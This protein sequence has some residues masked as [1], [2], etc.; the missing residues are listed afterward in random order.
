[1]VTGA[2]CIGVVTLIL[3]ITLVTNVSGIYA[4]L[5]NDKEGSGAVPGG[6]SGG[7][8]AIIKGF[9]V[10]AGEFLTVY[11]GVSGT[12]KTQAQ[13]VYIGLPKATMG[14]LFLQTNLFDRGDGSVARGWAL[15]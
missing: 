12:G 6:D 1:L 14:K 2:S 15:A 8:P 13:K 9:D 4:I 7:L 11:S 10:H 5:R 3:L